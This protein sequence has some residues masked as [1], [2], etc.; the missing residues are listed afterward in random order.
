MNLQHQKNWLKEM[1]LYSLGIILVLVIYF[2]VLEFWTLNYLLV[3][4]GERLE[5]YEL[6]SD[7]QDINKGI[8]LHQ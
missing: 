3:V 7:E 8:Y 1:L 6:V 4:L 5:S 2:L